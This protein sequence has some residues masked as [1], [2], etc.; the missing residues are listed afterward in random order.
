[1]QELLPRLRSDGVAEHRLIVTP[2][3]AIGA[4]VLLVA[5]ADGKLRAGAHVAIDDRSVTH[6]GPDNVIALGGDRR[7]Q[8]V[9][10]AAV[11][12]DSRARAQL[13]LNDHIHPAPPYPCGQG[14]SR[15]PA[16]APWARECGRA[17]ELDRVGGRGGGLGLFFGL[18]EVGVG[19]GGVVGDVDDVVDLGHGL[20]GGY[21]DSLAEGD[22]GHA[23]ALASAAEA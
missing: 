21:F 4:A 22:C 18:L 5:P 6:G 7:E 2:P 12:D 3:Q 17:G 14:L 23:A 16:G 1:V 13:R 11:D 8:R 19:P 9:K 15:F 20:G 10:R